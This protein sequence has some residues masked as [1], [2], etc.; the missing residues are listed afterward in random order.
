MDASLQ[1]RI[2]C[3]WDE[4]A[5]YEAARSEEALM[6]LVSAVAH[7]VDAQNAYWMGAVR[8]T[9][10]ERDPLRG[11]RPRVIRYAKPF[12]PDDACS[13]RVRQLQRGI[14]D[15]S[16]VAH[17][18]LAGTY[19]ACRMRDLMPAEW[20]NGP[21][22]QG[23][24]NRNIHDSLVV[25]VPVNPMAEAY[26]GFFRMRENDPFTEAQRAVAFYALRGLTWFHRQVLLA[27]GV[28]AA[29][30]PLSPMERRVLALLLTDR[31]EK[32]IAAELGVTPSTAHTYVR[33]VLRKLGVSGRNGL[34]S[35]W[36]GQQS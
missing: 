34:V 29:A 27:H 33:A 22:Y 5:A 12:K 7:M 14:P 24:R 17:A 1:E 9:D 4:L 26:Y 36:L 19:R 3:L 20:F 23:Y 28:Q 25:G 35:L 8:I 21:T 31:S 15:E 2:H 32:L 11:W 6:H 30:S 16:A 10:D 18:R 13:R